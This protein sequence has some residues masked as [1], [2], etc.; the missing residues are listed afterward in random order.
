MI[1]LSGHHVRKMNISCMKDE[2]HDEINQVTYNYHSGSTKTPSQD[3][4]TIHDSLL[5]TL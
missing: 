4:I 1:I 2:D 3:G 5:E